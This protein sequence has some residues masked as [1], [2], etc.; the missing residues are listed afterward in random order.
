MEGA[1]WGMGVL[2]DVRHGHGDVGEVVRRV[3]V[4]AIRFL[5][6]GRGLVVLHVAFF[7]LDVVAVDREE[8]GDIRVG[9]LA[10]VA[11]VE[12]VRGDLPVVV[13]VEL[14][15]VVERV[16]VEVELVKTRLLVD[17]CEGFSPGDFGRFAGV[18]I[19]PD[20]ALGVN[21]QVDWEEAVLFLFKFAQGVVVRGFGEF[22]VQTV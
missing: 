20:E 10:V 14:V 18:Q 8:G 7:E 2:A 16:L 17:A 9:C 6:F 13:R 1:G 12:V 22:A 11:L 19:H 4:V 15:R 5:L 21:M 3:D